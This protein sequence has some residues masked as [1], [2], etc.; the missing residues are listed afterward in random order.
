MKLLE[1]TTLFEHFYSKPG[2]Y[3]ITG[4]V[5]AIYDDRAIGGYEK[6]KTNILLNPSEVYDLQLYNYVIIS[7]ASNKPFYADVIGRTEN[8]E[9]INSASDI[10]KDILN[11]ELNY[12]ID[13][14]ETNIDDGWVHSFTLNEQKEAKEV[15]E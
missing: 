6:F 14:S 4:I 10:I 12:D 13:I 15:F 9:V 5:C 1:G 8:D 7:E 3:S 11:D 2:F